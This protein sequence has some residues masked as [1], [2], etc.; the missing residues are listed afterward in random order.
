MISNAKW[1][2][3][4]VENPIFSKV[5]NVEGAVSAATLAVT[6]MG[7]YNVE[8]DGKRVGDYV[9]T[10]GW[11]NYLSHTQYQTYDVTDMVKDG[12]KFDFFTGNGWAISKVGHE[13]AESAYGD[14]IALIFSLDIEYAD[15]KKVCYTSDETVDVYS[16]E[17]VYTDIYHGETIDRR[18]K[19]ELQGKATIDET[20]KTELVPQMGE[21]ILEMETIRPVSVFKTPKGEWVVDFGQNITG[22]VKVKVS[23]KSGDEIVFTHAEVLDSEGNFYNENYRSAKATARYI[24]GS[25]LE[26]FKPQFTFY[27]FRYIRLESFP[28]EPKRENFEAIEVHSDIERTGHFSCGYEPLNR[29]YSN[30]IW[31]QKDNF[32]DVPTDCPQRDERLGWTGDVLA[33]VKTAAINYDVEKF[34]KKWFY[35]MRTE[36][37][38]GGAIPAVIPNCVRNFVDCISAGW[39][40]ACIVAPW[41]IY[42]AYGDKAVL[43]DNFECM[44]GWIE[45]MHNFG[46]EEY[47]WLGDQHFGDWLGLDSPS[48]SYK[49]ITDEDFIASCYFAYSTSLFVKIGKIIGRDMSHY[50]DMYAKIK[51]AITDRYIEDGLPAIKTQTACVLLLQFDLT[52]NRE[53]VGNLLYKLIKDNGTRLTTGFIGTPHLLHTLSATGN[54]KTAY[55]LLLFDG[56]PSWLYSVKKGATTMWEHWDC[57]KEDGSFWSRDMNSFNH[58][59]YG[60]VYSWVFGVAAGI[61]PIEPKYTKV[62]VKPSPDKR[63]TYMDADIDSRMGKIRSS[64]RYMQ[65]FIRYEIDIPEGVTA[66]IELPDGQKYTVSGGKHI[67]HTDEV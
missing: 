16:S 48:G 50:E 36:Q 26:E 7:V 34:F 63:L 6:C 67:F 8:I 15:G 4:N 42:M 59:A 57:I 55:D 61:K 14:H 43:E 18:L 38:P 3:G 20:Y 64:W 1:I 24:M 9:L 45:H 33:F 65:G 27:G 35:D 11:T 32:L 39:G 53:G 51:Q 17:T 10:P 44:R 23:G 22:Y 40:D 62:S 66:E 25:D 60:S 13:E 29:L 12:S 19:P 2:R 41:E 21:N 31:G 58:Y 5:I 47:L 56:F 54:T 46:E 52:D 37:E 49:G 28:G 30:I